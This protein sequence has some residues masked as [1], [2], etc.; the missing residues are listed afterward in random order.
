MS[1]LSALGVTLI[2]LGIGGYI[3]SLI[4]PSHT[5]SRDE[6]EDV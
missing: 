2:A 1:I 3:V 6:H 5:H 4:R